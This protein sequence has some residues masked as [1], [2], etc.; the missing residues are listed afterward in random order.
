MCI[1]CVITLLTDQVDPDA[2][3]HDQTPY[4]PDAIVQI[5]SHNR[6]NLSIALDNESNDLISRNLHS[7]VNTKCFTRVYVVVQIDFDFFVYLI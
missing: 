2:S 4:Q 7:A 6:E 3:Y 5:D 1:V